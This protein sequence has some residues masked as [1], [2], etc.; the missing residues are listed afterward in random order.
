MR[1]LTNVISNVEVSDEA[2]QTESRECAV[3]LVMA[4]DGATNTVLLSALRKLNQDLSKKVG[5]GRKNFESMKFDPL[6]EF[7]NFDCKAGIVNVT[8]LFSYVQCLKTVR[9]CE[10]AS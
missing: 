1:T 10:D 7:L 9:W 4:A 6:N 5:D 2:E 3:R 8:R